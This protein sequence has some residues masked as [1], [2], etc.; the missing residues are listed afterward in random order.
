MNATQVEQ[1]AGGKLFS[2]GD[3]FVGANGLNALGQVVALG[4]LT[5]QLTNAFTAKTT[6][7]AG[8]TLSVTSNGAIDNQ[9]VMQGR[10]GEPERG[11]TADQ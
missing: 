1:S 11:R 10:C 2:G 6:L 4:N 3:L 9:S 5:L 7:A 8:K